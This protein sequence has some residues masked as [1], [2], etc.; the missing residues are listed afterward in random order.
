MR[1]GTP[2][3]ISFGCAILTLGVG[4]LAAVGCGRRTET[5]EPPIPALFP[6]A[7]T[8]TTLEFPQVRF[9][10]GTVC[11]NDRC[12]VRKVKLNR[13]LEPLYVNGRPIGFC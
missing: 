4:L 7:Y 3:L 12:P 10:D 13:R 1:A 5:P 11:A 2:S 6:A 9:A 8:D